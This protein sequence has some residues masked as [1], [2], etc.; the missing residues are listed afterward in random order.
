[1]NHVMRKPHFCLCENK[2]ADQLCSYCTADQRLC[3]YCTADQRLCFCHSDSTTSLLPN[4]K[5]SSFQPAS[6]TVQASLCLTGSETQKTNFLTSLLICPWSTAKDMLEQPVILIILFL[7]EPDRG[8]LP[9]V[10]AYFFYQ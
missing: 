7:D 8:R 9:V 6:E 1:M 10:G 4:S 2:G 3:S 5:I